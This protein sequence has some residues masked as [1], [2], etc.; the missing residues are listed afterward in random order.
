[1]YHTGNKRSQIP[2]PKNWKKLDY[3]LK[4]WYGLA[5]SP[6]ITGHLVANR[7]TAIA[8]ILWHFSLLRSHKT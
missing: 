7:E 5:T 6:G 2:F 3:V 4:L 8:F 1:M